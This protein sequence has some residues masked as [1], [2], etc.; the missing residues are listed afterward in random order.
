MAGAKSRSLQRT[1]TLPR[2][3]LVLILVVAAVVSNATWNVYQKQ[4]AAQEKRH[5]AARR[6]ERLTEREAFL[7]SELSRLAT[8]RGIEE[9]IRKKFR[10]TKEGEHMVVITGDEAP[11]VAPLTLPEPESLWAHVKNVF[12]AE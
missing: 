4:R 12:S 9:E 5:E 8:E 2:S 3:V 1:P 7:T 6:M 11:Q 10:V